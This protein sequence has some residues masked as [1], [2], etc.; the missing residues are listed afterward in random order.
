MTD[1][2][3]FKGCDFHLE[4]HSLGG[5]ETGI[6]VPEWKLA[7]DVGRGRRPFVRCDHIALTHTH[8]DHAGGLAYV[9]SLRQLF[10]M[11][12]PTVYVHAKLADALRD[13]LRSWE[14]LQRHELQCEIV[15]VEPGDRYELRRGLWLEPFRT[16]HVVSSVGYTVTRVTEKLRPELVD[17]SREEI[18]RLRESGAP[19]TSPVR[20]R[21]LSFTG[22]TLPEAL[23][24]DPSWASARV[25]IHEATFLDDSKPYE[26]C[27]AGGH[28]HLSDLLERAHLFTGDHVVLSHFSQVHRWRDVPELLRPFADRISGSL[29]ALPTTEGHD[30][31]GPLGG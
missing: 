9:L 15:P 12:P 16:R 24:E 31:L 20:D 19:V 21:L 1:F 30:V 22:D 14:P 28:T 18:V 11:K 6:I 8:M 27:R 25:V 5:I 29:Y 26:A 17:A 10:R 2:T 3:G 23:D 13:M 7:L 4:G